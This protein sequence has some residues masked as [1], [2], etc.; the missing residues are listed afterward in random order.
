MN[1]R[2]GKLVFCM[3]AAVA[4]V[5]IGLGVVR[6]T[7]PIDGAT[8]SFSDRVAVGAA[9]ADVRAL[10]VGDLDTDGQL[11]V[12][13]GA[14]ATLGAI[15]NDGTP[16]DGWPAASE[17]GTAQSDIADLALADFDRDGR[18]DVASVAGEA[19]SGEVRLWQNPTAPFSGVWA[20]SNTLTNS[21]SISMT[22][23]AVGDLNVDG[24]ADVVVGQADG[25]VLA[26]GNAL[27]GS[28]PFTSPWGSTLYVAETG[29][30][31]YDVQVADIDRDGF[32]DVIVA[33]G[34]GV[35]IWQN[36]GSMVAGVWPVSRTVGSLGGLARSVALGDLDNDGAIDIVAADDA[37]DVTTWRNPLASADPFTTDWGTGT[38]VGTASGG[39][40]DLRVVDV[41]HDGDE[42]VIGA[43]EVS[44]ESWQ[45]DGTP[46]DAAWL[47]TVLDI[48]SD[49][50]YVLAV[51]DVDRDGDSDVVS[52]R[53]S[54]EDD[55][56]VLLSNTLV[57]RSMP[58]VRTAYEVGTLVNARFWDVLSV[59]L[60]GDGDLDLLTGSDGYA[61]YELAAWEND[62]T[63]FV[64]G[65]P[66]HDIGD[67]GKVL[68][69]DAGDLDGDGDID[70]VSGQSNSPRLLV[71]ENDGS[72]FSGSWSYHAIGTPPAQVESVAVGDL[73][74]DGDLD[75]VSATG[76]DEWSA[77]SN[78]RVM[79]WEND[80]TPFS[81][82]WVSND[83][84]IVTY[85]VHAVAL[86]DLD[87]DGWLDIVAGVNH[88]PAVGSSGNP[89]PP[90]N[91]YP[92]YELRAYQN[93]GSP[94]TGGWAETSVGRDPETVTFD[95]GNYH[96]YWGATIYAVAIADLDNDG[97]LDILSAEHLEGD[98]Q[99]KAWENDGMP[100]DGL[101]AEEHWTW[102]PTAL[103]VYAPWM[104]SSVYDI[105][106]ED[107]NQ[108]GYV[109]AATISE[110]SYEAVVWENSGSPFGAVI[111]DTT[112]IRY[113]MGQYT[114]EGGL[115]ITV[116]D[117]DSD[118]DPDLVY[119]GGGYWD[120][121][122]E[123][124]LLAWRNRGGSADLDVQ[125]AVGGQVMQGDTI[126]VFAIRFAHS[127]ITGD[128]DIELAEIRLLM[129]ES[130]GDPL[131]SS[132]ANAS[133]D[134]LYVYRDANGNMTWEATDTPVLTVT[135]L[136]LTAGVQTITF[137]DGDPLLQVGPSDQA[138]VLF[139]V[140][141]VAPSA[142]FENPNT[143][144]ATLDGDASFIVEDVVSD[145]SVSIEDADPD[146][147]GVIMFVGPATH[148]VIEDTPDA[149]GTEVF[150]ATLATGNS[151]TVY[152][153]SHD[154]ADNFRANVAVAWSLVDVVGGVVAGDLTAGGGNGATFT[155]G[156]VG[157]ARVLADHATLTDD[158]TGF[159]TVT[160]GVK[161]APDPAMVGSAA[162]TVVTATVVNDD[163]SPVADGTEVTLSTS[164]GGFEGVVSTTQTTV[165]G[166]VTA[167]LTSAELGTAKVTA[168]S[169]AQTGWVDVTFVPGMPD[170]V[171]LEASP[172]TISVGGASAAITATVTDAY[173]NPVADGT[174][175]A[176]AT[177]LGSITS[178]HST[179]DGVAVAT[180]TSGT[181]AD[182]AVVTATA[183]SASGQVTVAFTP[184][185]P[186]TVAVEADPTSISVGGASA[187]ITATVT[188]AYGNPVADGTGV[189]FATTLGSVTSPHS[190]TDGMAVATLTSGTVADDAVV[191]AT[192]GSASGQVTV[193]F[194]PGNPATV[195]VEADPTSVSVGGAS[196]A[197][198][199]TVT[200]AYGNPVADGT[201]VAFATTLGS[202]T[203]PHSTT[204][205]VAVATLTSGTVAADAVVTAT[206]G[207]ASGQV[208]VA[209]TPGNPAIVV[210]AAVPATSSVEGSIVVTAEVRDLWGNDV[211]DGTPVT[212]TVALDL[213]DGGLSPATDLTVDGM[214]STMITSTRSGSGLASVSTV[215]GVT[216]STMITFTPGAL[217][218]FD[219]TGYPAEVAAGTGFGSD[220]LVTAHDAYGNIKTDYTGA[221]Y[222]TATDPAA[223]LPFTIGHPYVFTPSDGGQRTFAGGGFVLRTTGD[224]RLT[225]TDGTVARTSDPITVVPGA[226]GGFQLSAPE[227]VIAGEP[228]SVT[229]T[230]YDT[231]GNVKTDYTGQV[232]FASSD[233]LAEL[234][235]DD[236]TG[237]LA[238]AKTF[239]IVLHASG[240]QSITANDG[241]ADASVETTVSFK[242]YLPLVCRIE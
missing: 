40:L 148:V 84:Y 115:C 198:T 88:A 200:D 42:D 186:A 68:S 155:A 117:L 11:D 145:T 13:Y 3:L 210:L 29:V 213:G 7:P 159:I 131:T 165:D 233:G 30:A 22:C 133:I 189:A 16:L 180:L 20:V 238:G 179:T 163:L 80:G 161:V 168:T 24:F 129:E 57:H 97:D 158:T 197:I 187:A 143:L 73:D 230:A 141:E 208:T 81:G 120:A 139:L 185:N 47:L 92:N 64:A 118:G 190:T 82:G 239:V 110:E 207:S 99:V 170:S 119:G 150:T 39:V 45:N 70:L 135:T 27:A 61:G 10:A 171:V 151:L 147:T 202:I 146:V 96:G 18:V 191:T 105:V 173:G 132:E 228:F 62:G 59:D 90:E 55:E 109:D 116:S 17:I 108:D 37:G 167:Q 128:H 204:D 78:Y 86:G 209:F 219:L 235:V 63:P 160:L 157:A 184:G 60:D 36:P 123:H 23:V 206:A 174:G 46:F 65:W 111:T 121:S 106:A 9:S 183:G 114:S 49:A 6:A 51:G 5:T 138:I 137:S 237:W 227:N 33:A 196:A 21:V 220:V 83:V 1:V 153:N 101:P 229:V 218:Y 242:I 217:S 98:Y 181:V 102:Q 221:V 25:S 142:A 199:A 32:L 4:L 44:V 130:E 100:F 193:T 58:F 182:D 136:S 223:T 234:P 72:P 140:V 127:G 91:W 176:F 56:I 41:D 75:I 166:V 67:V 134:T 87:N 85:S 79:A 48:S 94:F 195:A 107:V 26:W 240:L 76:L 43:T 31:V 156:Q 28:V 34:N 112:W 12:V 125:A 122:G 35:Q 216:G 211:M 231:E 164:L 169:G 74:K 54:G 126:D 215:G 77:S 113:N 194:T 222:F 103:G 50:V 225:V 149:S 205:G 66:R 104:D 19:G 154:D 236:G 89:A 53:G 214:A 212:F 152:A 38:G 241:V 226:L 14:G 2:I 95:H 203:S 93:D 201:G 124:G 8:H 69:I 188:D 192:A 175:V 172:D 177:T 178:P 15:A 224:Y 162:G 52:G 144:I 232:T 71:W